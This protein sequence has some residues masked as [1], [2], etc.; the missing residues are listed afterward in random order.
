MPPHFKNLVAGPADKKLGEQVFS[1]LA[2]QF[3]QKTR[4]CWNYGDESDQLMEYTDKLK[5]YI[6][7][8]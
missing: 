8:L 4:S 7:N 2:I 3:K 1:N 5:S 6:Y